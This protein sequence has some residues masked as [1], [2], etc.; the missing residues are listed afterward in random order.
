MKKVLMLLIV[1]VGLPLLFVLG[2]MNY[3]KE[4][5]ISIL[6]T[7]GVIEIITPEKS[8]IPLGIHVVP[9]LTNEFVAKYKY[10]D[11]AGFCVALK[12]NKQ[13]FNVFRNHNNGVS[14]DKKHGLNG[15]IPMNQISRGFN[16]NNPD[17]RSGSRLIYYDKKYPVAQDANKYGFTYTT[18]PMGTEFLLGYSPVKEKVE[19]LDIFTSEF[20]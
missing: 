14:N 18:Y 17:Y 5:P 2:Y 20:Y 10:E 1:L 8:K 19:Y 9:R 16:T 6:E 12:V 7:T 11:S 3:S 13:Y 4:E 15:C